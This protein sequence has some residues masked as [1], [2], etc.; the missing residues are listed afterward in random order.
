MNLF[1]ECSKR[2]GTNPTVCKHDAAK[3]A[4]FYKQKDVLF[5]DTFANSKL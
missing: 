5:L 2:I 4:N 1:V 3:N